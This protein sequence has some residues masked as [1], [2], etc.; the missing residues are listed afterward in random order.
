MNRRTFVISVGSIAATGGA[1][2]GSGA[3]DLIEADRTADITL[4]SD[5]AALLEL[6]DNGTSQFVDSTGGTDGDLLQLKYTGSGNASG[7]NKS[8][9]TTIE[10]GFKIGNNAS[11]G[12]GVKIAH[13]AADPSAVN[14][15][16]DTGKT[17]AV[18]SL[19]TANG[20]P[21]NLDA[22]DSANSTQDSFDVTIELD[23]TVT[24]LSGLTTITVT[25][26][27]SAY[28]SSA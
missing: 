9:V 22:Y 14:L 13:D 12:V 16:G 7:A 17:T 1:A 4:A 23:T 15:Y 20:D 8:A 10:A 3:F 26:D 2:L 18:E 28:T 21:H 25:A 27:P 24:D 19:P 6:T 5:S 11:Q